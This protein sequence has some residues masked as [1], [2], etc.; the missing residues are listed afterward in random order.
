[1]SLKYSGQTH[2]NGVA[3]ERIDIAVIEILEK[4]FSLRY[5]N[6]DPTLVSIMNSVSNFE[7][8]RIT[9][10]FNEYIQRV[11]KKTVV[12]ST[13]LLKTHAP[14]IESVMITE[15]FEKVF[16]YHGGKYG[17][18]GRGKLYQKDHYSKAF[19][20]VLSSFPEVSLEKKVQLL[21][22]IFH[23]D[24]K[25]TSKTTTL[26]AAYVKLLYKA[27]KNKDTPVEWIVAEEL[28]I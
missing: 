19:K 8:L 14:D 20:Y 11:F 21:N 1:M 9:D 12:E 3:L 5:L 10:T 4:S 17:L 18:N 15:V 23:K 6:I 26:G 2:F 13:D 22:L 16:P 28:G 7:Y 27:S 24:F 25:A